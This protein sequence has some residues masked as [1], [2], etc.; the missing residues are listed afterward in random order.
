MGEDTRIK[1]LV[2]VIGS[3]DGI[4]QSESRKEADR[5]TVFEALC[6]QCSSHDRVRW[7]IGKRIFRCISDGNCEGKG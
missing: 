1:G 3:K 2:L 5:N 7:L 4:D 6:G